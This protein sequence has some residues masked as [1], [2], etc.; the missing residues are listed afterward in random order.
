MPL[1]V[2]DYLCEACDETQKDLLVDPS[3]TQVCPKC[4][5]AMVRLFSA[6]R[7]LD[8]EGRFQPFWSDTM[9][10][11]INDREDLSKL[12]QYAKDN[13]LTNVGH[14]KMKPDRAA[15]RYNY[16]ND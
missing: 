13:G 3:E 9:Q 5:K 14:T 1:K 2:F 10:K 4:S 15:I 7:S 12:R 16:E 6:P 8:R 11:R